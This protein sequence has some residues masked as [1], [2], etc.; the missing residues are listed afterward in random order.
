M[1]DRFKFRAWNKHHKKMYDVYQIDFNCGLIFCDS[2]EGTTHTFGFIDCDLLQCTG[3]KDKNGVLIFEGDI[4][5]YK[6]TKKITIEWCTETASFMIFGGADWPVFIRHNKSNDF[7]I[8]GNIH[9]NYNN[10]DGEGY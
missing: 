2:A 4:L 1:S 5:T 10:T 6:G 8:I 7:E 3:L 9:T